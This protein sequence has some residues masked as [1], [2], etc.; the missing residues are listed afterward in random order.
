LFGNKWLEAQIAAIAGLGRTRALEDEGWEAVPILPNPIEILPMG[1]SVREGN[2]APNVHPDF[3]YAAVAAGLGEIA[4]NGL[5]LTEKFGSRQRL[6][7]VI[8]DAVIEPTPLLKKSVCDRCGKCAA[9]CPLGAISAD[10][11]QTVNVCGKKMSVAEID[12][13]LCAKCKNG[14]VPNRFLKKAKPDRVAAACGRACLVH[15]EEKKRLGNR[16]ENDFRQSP[17]WALDADGKTA[18]AKK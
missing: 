13:S 8:T 2:P 6:H 18:V 9:A 7:M 14:A 1:V 15:L 4:Y 11:S 5:L 10:K 17:E 16:F 3:N 12:Y